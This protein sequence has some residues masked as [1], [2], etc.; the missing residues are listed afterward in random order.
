MPG[1]EPEGIDEALELWSPRVRS[2]LERLG[3]LATGWV[4]GR[5]VGVGRGDGAGVG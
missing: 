3:P 4:A 5:W 1:P 2:E